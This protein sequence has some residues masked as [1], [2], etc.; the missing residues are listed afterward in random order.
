MPQANI[1]PNDWWR[2]SD[3]QPVIIKPLLGGLTNLNY[4]ISVKQELFV[5]RKNSPISEAL[6][7]NRCAEAKALSRADEAGLCAPLIYYDDQHQYM[8]SRYLGDKTWS[9]SI[10]HDLSLLAKLLRGIHQ[11][12]GIDADLNVEHKISCYWQAID[13]NATFTCELKSLDSAASAHITSAKALNNGHALCHNDLLRSNLIMNDKHA[14]YAIDWEYAAMS[15]PFY[16]LA[17]VIEGNSLNTQQQERLLVNYLKRQITQEDWQRL[18]H[19]KIIY[20]YLCLLW[21]GVQY[22]GGAMSS[23]DIAKDIEKQIH[24]LHARL[25]GK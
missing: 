11:L 18:H 24:H 17:V 22:C 8:V 13:A 15:D 16:E 25:A 2:W 4:L 9:A 7:L 3:S 5:L 6:N 1:I 23:A 21:Y 12:P 10:D 19:W 14:L 20:D